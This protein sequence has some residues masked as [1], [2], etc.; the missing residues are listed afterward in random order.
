MLLW[1]DVQRYLKNHK[2]EEKLAPGR[3]KNVRGW[4]KKIKM[5]INQ[6]SLRFRITF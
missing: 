6:V 2:K 3:M 5:T 4:L 1:A